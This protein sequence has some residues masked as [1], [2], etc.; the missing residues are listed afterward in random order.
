MPAL[1]AANLEY[2]PP[3][4]MRHTWATWALRAG[5][6]TF[7]VA[8]RMGTSVSQIEDTYGHLAIDSED[9]ERFLMDSFDRPVIGHE[10]GTAAPNQG[11][12]LPTQV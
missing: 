4:D 9:H 2:R 11:L 1:E 8:R 10:L 6:P 3:Y 12:A 5:M 7:T